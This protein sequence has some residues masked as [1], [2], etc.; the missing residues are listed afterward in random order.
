MEINTVTVVISGVSAVIGGTVSH[1]ISWLSGRRRELHRRKSLLRRLV[2]ELQ[3]NKNLS[4]QARSLAHTEA[5]EKVLLDYPTLLRDVDIDDAVKKLKT[6]QNYAM[7]IRSFAQRSFGTQTID[8]VYN[9][10][11]IPAIDDAKPLVSKALDYWCRQ[12]WWWFW[13]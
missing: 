8:Q 11:L 10:Q 12:H 7:V 1:I 4:R 3:T 6:I 2:D 5:L 13:R 9:T